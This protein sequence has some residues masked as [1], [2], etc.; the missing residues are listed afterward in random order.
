MSAYNTTQLNPD[1]T[2]EKHV[3]HRDQ[4]AHYF[5]WSHVI[6]R[7]KIGQKILDVGCGSGNLFEVMYRNR[8]KGQRYVGLEYRKQIVQ[9]NN[10]KY[11]DIGWCEFYQHDATQ[12]FPVKDDWDMITS[13]EMLEHVGRENVETVLKNI[14]AQMSEKTILLISTPIYD[15]DVGAAE[16]HMIN[17]EVGEMTYDELKEKIENAGL[18]IKKTWGTF[19]SQKDYKDLMNDW[20]KKFFEAVE[21]YFDSNLLANLMAPMFP[22]HS[23]NCM[24]ELTL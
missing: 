4:F 14:K 6:K 13:F 11:K 3:Y 10:E 15:K 16:N 12:P 19:A 24:W 1:T 5:R 7:L 21:D 9:K 20:Q 23:R 17:G 8:Y 22:E 18:K 2:F